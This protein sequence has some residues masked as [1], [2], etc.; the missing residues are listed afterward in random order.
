MTGVQPTQVWWSADEIAAAAL[1]DLPTTK[2][3][4]N[5]MADRFNWRAQTGHARRRQGRGGGWEYHWALFPSRAQA[6]LLAV[7]APTETAPSRQ[8]DRA[9]IWTWFDALPAKPKAEA[10]RRLDILQSVELLERGGQ[11]KDLSVHMIATRRDVSH[12]TIWNWFAAVEG[13]RPDDR[14]PHLAPRHR[15]TRRKV[16]R[17]EVSEAFWDFLKSDFLR[18]ER[19]TFAA[20]Y[21]RA[22]RIADTE[23]WQTAPERTMRRRL[24]TEVSATTITLCRKGVDALKAMYP[25][26]TR[27]RMSLHAM[28]AVNADYHRFD[29]FVRWPS[30]PG[31]NSAQDEIVR[32]QM[33][34]FQDIFSGRILSWRIDKTPNKVGVSLALG[35]MIERFGI[36]DRIVLDN[37]REFANKFL[38]G[39]TPTRFRFKVKDDDIP[40][41]LTT[42]GVK[43]HWATPYSGQSKPIERAFRDLAED[44]AKDPRFAGA[45]TGNGIDAKPDNYGSKAIPLDRF[46]EVVAEG[47]E[48]HNARAGRR[49]QTTMGRSILETF[50]ASYA[51]APIRKA[52]AEQR[53]L[54]LMGAE[55]LKADSRSGAIK[56]MGNKYY[57]EWM[58]EIAGQKVVVRFDPAN[59]WDGLHIYALSG[60]YLGVADCTENAGFFDLA[61]A[62][63]HASARR[64]W[65]NAEKE[66]AK[67]AAVF[68]AAQLGSF[69]DGAAAKAPQETTPVEAKIVRPAAF[70]KAPR[71]VPSARTLSAAE[72]EQRAVFVANFGDHSKASE[73]AETSAKEDM[74]TRFAKAQEMEARLADGEALSPDMERW[75]SGYRTTPEY[76]AMRDLLGAFGSAEGEGG[77][78]G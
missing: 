41:V 52:T 66:A 37:G 14:L 40:G 54:W 50:E 45:Y 32:P 17:V 16:K 18:P 58:Y 2:R 29:V 71:P 57:A 48:E 43:V 69:M 3:R 28:E 7:S 13:V 64:K 33:V 65:M 47:I 5:A 6:A 24:E 73:Q 55:G 26:Q 78:A 72:Q 39:G 62:R 20:C 77:A 76:K 49:G 53:R 8:V 23:G 63:N 31:S 25:A 67:A 4:V 27:D 42:L 60:E 19:P 35:D 12:R 75:L 22:A 56:F 51:E 11:T 68:D 15:A 36:P 38:T 59:I 1:P 46:I 21:R 9:E 61:E 74:R 44:I 70:E 30:E 10:Q 34:A